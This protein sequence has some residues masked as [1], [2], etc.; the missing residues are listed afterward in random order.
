MQLLSFFNHYARRHWAYYLSGL[1]FLLITTYVTSI[2][3]LKI[4]AAIDLL[5]VPDA[6]GEMVQS[7]VLVIIGL[8][9]VLA[10]CRTLSRVLIFMP[11]RLIEFQLRHD[12]YQKLM[13]LS[14]RFFDRQKI[15]DLMSRYINDIQSLRLMSALGFLH[16]VN[17]VVTYSLIFY[18][19]SLINLRLAVLVAVPIPIA[20]VLVQLFAARLYRY[21]KEN[22]EKLGDVTNFF[23]ENLSHILTLKS[24]C[25]ESAVLRRFEV[26]NDAYFQ[27]TIRLAAI[28][29]VM[30]PFIGI[31]GS[32][33]HFILF[34]V[35]AKMMVEG[36]L[37]VGEFVAMSTYIGLLA[38]PTASL[39][40]IINIIGRGLSALGRVS[41]IMA[42]PELSLASHSEKMAASAPHLELDHVTVLG[43]DDHVIL[44]DVSL[45]LAPG[46][47]LG[48]FGQTGS[49]KTVLAEVLTRRRVPDSGAYVVDGTDSEAIPLSAFYEQ[50]SY[51]AQQPFLFS[52]TI[53]ENVAFSETDTSAKQQAYIEKVT[54]LAC[55]DRDIRSF[56]DG[57]ETIIGEKGII[58][59]GGQ[60]NRL[61]YARALYKPHQVLI[62]DDI[63]SAVDHKTESEVLAHLFE[64]ETAKS[65]VIISHRISALTRCDQIIVLDRGRIVAQGTHDEL[66]AQP[67]VYADTWA[68][69]KMMDPID[70]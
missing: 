8:A 47:S 24:Y 41:A 20:M 27:S 59:S 66:T 53:S 32:I 70:E 11:G 65:K 14:D 33:G 58:L 17:T 37:T 45:Q 43:H 12:V 63:L 16:I 13:V 48:I 36:I 5:G 30:F 9:C 49:G 54:A 40:W 39:A 4:K 1:V 18:Q 61:T 57:Y 64:S 21:I 35:G 25:A 19:M 60:K 2:I 52:D 31:L 44:D 50:V 38:W 56:P 55:V 29:S 34:F 51:V 6:T 7:A 42:E 26:E 28:R 3:P 67:G 46:T 10:V 68:Y 22:Q 23:V 15:G 69:Q 62:L